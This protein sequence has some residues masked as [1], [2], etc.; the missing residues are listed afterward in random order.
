MACIKS[1][2][3]IPALSFLFVLFLFSSPASGEMTTDGTMGRAQTISGPRYDITEDHGRQSGNN[4][5]HSFHT[6]NV[7]E[8]E[9]AVFSGPENIQNVIARV[10]GGNNSFI[11]GKLSCTIPDSD[12]YLL[13][14]AG[15]IFGK[16]AS[17]DIQGS[18]HI[19]TSD[20]LRMGDAYFHAGP[21]ESELLSSA[22]PSAF[23]FLD[24]TPA[25]IVLKSGAPQEEEASGPELSISQGRTISIIGG[26]IVIGESTS[27][28]AP[29]G[30]IFMAAVKSPGEVT[31]G[32]D[33]LQVSSQQGGD[34]S[35]LNNS[36]LD[37]SGDPAGNIYIHGSNVS[38]EHATI[39]SENYS[40]ENEEKIL[41]PDNAFPDASDGIKEDV[42]PPDNTEAII[43]DLPIST[44]EED[45]P[46]DFDLLPWQ[47]G[48]RAGH[49]LLRE[50]SSINSGTS[51]S[52]W[53]GSIGIWADGSI[54]LEDKSD[55]S[56][57]SRGEGLAGFIFM[58]TPELFLSN[59]AG[60]TSESASP[61]AGGNAGTIELI[62]C[63]FLRM[64]K[65]SVISTTTWGEGFAGGVL[66]DAG[67][68]LLSE[69]ASISS[70][71][72]STGQGGDAGYLQIIGAERIEI[73]GDS[74][75]TTS[76]RG[77]GS[78]GAIYIET[79]ALE[80]E[81]GGS[82][83]ST[84][85]LGNGYLTEPVL[86]PE[87]DF[88]DGV[89][90]E[91]SYYP[92]YI[93]IFASDHIIMTHRSS[94]N[95]STS[96]TEVAGD[97]GIYT[98]RLEM[99]EGSSLIS[100][101]SA[102]VN[103]GSAGTILVQADDTITLAK[104]SSVVTEAESSGMGLIQMVAEKLVEMEA[105]RVATD[106]RSGK[107]PSGNVQI[108]SSRVVTN[109]TE[110]SAKADE[111]AGGNIL[112]ISDL[113]LASSDSIIT[114]SSRLG[115]NGEVYIDSMEPNLS[116]DI[117]LLPSSF[118]ELSDWV[119]TPCHTRSGEKISSFVVHPMDSAPWNPGDWQA[120]PLPMPA[121][122]EG[123]PSMDTSLPEFRENPPG[124]TWEGEEPC[125]CAP[126]SSHIFSEN[127][128][129]ISMDLY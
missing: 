34:V 4:L 102:A 41:P 68:I 86:P 53:A 74:T 120:S 116:L 44:E 111:G 59:G 117:P 76:S 30:R 50:G 52:G 121:I 96:G 42:P 57:G 22:P 125:P 23:G 91:E 85:V 11:D 70:S 72:Q 67:H 3:P 94:I 81:N 6:F 129:R 90:A 119:K 87:L 64:E 77:G 89:F 106:V 104:G 43:P 73:R 33:G 39:R 24:N 112:I 55:I 51:G 13:N 61:G 49:L 27:V 101:S 108:E 12:L 128:C 69:N 60:I 7:M 1:P 14:P 28:S 21:V 103:G 19:S 92:G 75:I 122:S 83:S 107:G 56:T 118:L 46:Y 17:L 40:S 97:I 2:S 45:I 36:R 10:T 16:N 115:I 54:R 8:N 66:M 71:S 18:F 99:N 63:D 113:Y 25:S 88:N 47:I 29:A 62:N 124:G 26:N 5:F 38:L 78:A 105:S 37:V 32:E 98:E 31:F 95:T 110:I 65:E 109:Q 58:D 123:E 100:S 80:L 79:E 127:P 35:L 126:D 9:N 82:I 84:S 114:A 15:V 20:Y 93:D 48:I